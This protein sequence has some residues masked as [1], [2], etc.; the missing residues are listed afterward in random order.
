MRR[1]K[2]KA[3]LSLVLKAEFP[4]LFWAWTEN[5]TAFMSPCLVGGSANQFICTG[6]SLNQRHRSEF[7]PSAAKSKFPSFPRGPLKRSRL[8]VKSWPNFIHV[9]VQ[10]SWSFPGRKKKLVRES[11]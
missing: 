7:D 2:G 1:S 5:N 11:V 3:V 8:G 10:F 6:Y 4:S 9:L